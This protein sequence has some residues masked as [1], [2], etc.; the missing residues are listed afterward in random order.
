[1]KYFKTRNTYENSTGTNVVSLINMRAT[2]Y[3]WW[4]YLKIINGM[5]VFNGYPYSN[6]TS[7][8]QSDCLSL[9]RRHGIEVDL[10]VYTSE[11]LDNIPGVIDEIK[12][13][14]IAIDR[15]IDNPNSNNAKNIKRLRELEVLRRQ[16]E[17]L[18]NGPESEAA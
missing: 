14:I 16:V 2:S 12:R 4:P 6:T 17:L 3:R 5:L 8:H 18:S 15:A 11:H 7:R 10:W 1:M 9:L 13:N